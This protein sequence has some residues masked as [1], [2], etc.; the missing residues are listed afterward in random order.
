M[1]REALKAAIGDEC[2][3]LTEAELKHIDSA[4]TAWALHLSRSVRTL[5]SEIAAE[6][7]RA[8]HAE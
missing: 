7:P 3:S 6:E 4:E 5:S 2:A 1:T 8:Q